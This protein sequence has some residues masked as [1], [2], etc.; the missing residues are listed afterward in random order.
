[1]IQIEAIGNILVEKG[2]CT[3][4]E[5][6]AEVQIEKPH[7]EISNRSEL[8]GR[9]NYKKKMTMIDIEKLTNPYERKAQIY[10]SLICLLPIIVTIFFLYHEIFDL[11]I[12]LTTVIVSLGLFPL[13]ANLVRTPGKRL[14]SN[15]FVLWDGMPSVRILRHSDSTLPK[16]AKLRYHSILSEHTGINAP[17]TNYERENP[18]KADEIY[19]SWSDYLRGKTRNT[20]TYPLVF[21]EN[22]NYGFRRNLLGIRI[23]CLIVGFFCLLLI[24]I[25]LY[26]ESLSLQVDIIIL[27]TLVF[28]YLLVFLLVVNKNW[29]KI[30]ADAYAKQLIESLNTQ[31]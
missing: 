25:R 15:L 29:V 23:F 19:L 6:L 4:E 12:K 26:Q 7:E 11:W 8:P 31:Q 18:Q 2:I 13:L 3:R 16:P 20:A 30:T 9:K 5:L 17:S 14:E 22:V 10:P 24:A 21:K 27:I 1:M 28:L